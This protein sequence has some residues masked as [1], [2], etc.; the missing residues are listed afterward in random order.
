[1]SKVLRKKY[2]ESDYER[3]HTR[4]VEEGICETELDSI[5]DVRVGCIYDTKTIT[6]GPIREVEV[7]PLYL[8]RICQRN[9]DLKIQEK[10]RKI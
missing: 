3:L 1:M 7:F 8:K 4:L 5:V 9:G 10:H 6:S 2:I